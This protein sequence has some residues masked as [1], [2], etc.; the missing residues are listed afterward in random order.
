MI[1]VRRANIAPQLESETEGA[2]DAKSLFE[3]KVAKKLREKPDLGKS[4]NAAVAIELSGDGG[5]RWVIDFTK[6]PATIEADS[7][8]HAVT[9]VSMGADTFVKMSSGEVD[10]QTAF[11]TGKI[12]VDGN[13]GVAI[14]LGE[15][16]S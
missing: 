4:V 14:K 13:L 3:G 9:T 11:L 15:L 12:K 1:R 6:S 5:G 16:L 7:D 10:P 8:A 2:M